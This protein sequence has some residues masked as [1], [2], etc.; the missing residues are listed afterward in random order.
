MNQNDYD[1]SNLYEKS[2]SNTSDR[3]KI[4]YDPPPVQMQK[5][6]KPF[7]PIPLLLIA[8][9]LFLFLGGII[10][11]TNTWNMLP[12]VLRACGLL[13]ASVIAFSANAL[14]DK[15][16]RLHRT[17]LAFFILGCIFLPLG[18]AGIGAFQL[19]GSWFS[20]QGDGGYLLLSIIC[21]SFSACT[22]F[23]QRKYQS[24][25]LVWMSLAGLFGTWCSLSNFLIM[26][27]IDSDYYI[28]QTALSGIFCT[29][30]AVTASI[31]CELF[32]R[33]H[34]K[35]HVAKAI[36]SYLY[37]VNI[38]TAFL[39]RVVSSDAKL[40]AMILSFITAVL[41][42]NSRF[43]SHKFHIGVFGSVMSLCMAFSQI[44]KLLPEDFGFYVHYDFFSFENFLF[45]CGMT[46][47]LLMSLRNM[48][49]L[50]P[51]LKETYGNAGM[52]FTVPV[53]LICVPISLEKIHSFMIILYLCLL[54]GFF[55]TKIQKNA[56]SSD[57]KMLALHLMLVFT[58]VLDAINTQSNLIALLLVMASLLLL[59]Q[60][61]IRKKLWPLAVSIGTC[62][63]ILFL[64]FDYPHILL[65]WLC[66]A[67]M[68]SGLIYAHI[69]ERFLLETY[70]AL[71]FITFLTVS[72]CASLNL[73]TEI[74]IAWVLSFL[75][76]TILYLAEV[77]FFRRHF[78]TQNTIPY[79]ET[80]SVLISVI[81]CF[82]ILNDSNTSAEFL[83]CFPLIIFSAAFC[84][85]LHN[86]GC[87][88]QLFMLFLIFNVMIGEELD[89]PAAQFFCYLI[90][91]AIYAGMGRLL[92]PQFRIRENG[93]VQ[94]DWPLIMGI[95]PIFGAAF[96]ID[97]YPSI[98][99]CLFLAC[100]S[101]LYLGRVNSPYK[102]LVSASA[103]ACLSIFFHNINDPFDV[104]ME[105]RHSDMKTLQILLYLFPMHLFILSLL[106][107][108]PESYKERIHKARFGMYCFTTL[109]LLFASLSFGNAS[110][111]ILMM[112]FS[113]S[114]LAG[115]FFF[116]K[117]RWFTLGFSVLVLMTIKLTWKFWT[118]LHWGAYL[119]LAGITLIG[120]ASYSE[121]KNRYHA[122]HPDEPAKKLDLFKTWTW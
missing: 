20:F 70:C 16:F 80:I 68:L 81:C 109:C 22:F 110:D 55:F 56:L 77:F 106:W 113:F 29:A 8:G 34:D 48:P 116:K 105:L 114:I 15:I 59:I 6:K 30:F 60:A 98:L 118:S 46:A 31:L 76:L 54:I 1:Y 18:I 75:M 42:C 67:G 50:R 117:L 79:L 101:L 44:P 90:L 100:Y 107:I 32:L 3:P 73:V 94:T 103:F 102:P 83:L 88:P 4:Y 36:P 64:N 112:L 10:F 33:K 17:G 66:T 12:D 72:C 13:S 39:L 119:F 35:P 47:L 62:C 51:E 96:T 52:I 78:R 74:S 121:Y 99:T 86:T 11:L 23:G 45:T 92:V 40:A 61:F 120:I 41:F 115:S 21:M 26:Q 5:P 69:T 122:E 108:L 65:F 97:W 91:L 82:Y 7:N 58:L 104:F 85:K 49:K 25:F 19:F 95:L 14:A 38:M 24:G 63:S 28:L 53:L 71:T 87:I 111:A 9:V 37:F 84:R 93:M 2:N 27:C 43:I 57:S 89:S